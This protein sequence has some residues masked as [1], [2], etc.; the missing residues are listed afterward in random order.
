[1]KYDLVEDSLVKDIENRAIHNEPYTQHEL[2]AI[3]FVLVMTGNY[4]HQRHTFIGDIRPKNILI[5]KNDCS[6]K[7]AT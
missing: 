1:M 3:L 6:L 7:I 5:T 2:W 4:L